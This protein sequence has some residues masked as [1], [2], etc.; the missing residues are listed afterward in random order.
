MGNRSTG[1][2]ASMALVVG[3]PSSVSYSALIINRHQEM[4]FGNPGASFDYPL[5]YTVGEANSYAQFE[6]TS[7]QSSSMVAI[8]G[9]S[10]ADGILYLGG[11]NEYGGGILYHGSDLGSKLPSTFADTST[12]LYRS[13][14]SV[15]EPVLDFPSDNNHI[16]VRLDR[17]ADSDNLDYFGMGPTGG[18]NVKPWKKTFMLNKQTTS[19]SINIKLGEVP[20][21]GVG[22]YSIKY[23]VGKCK[24]NSPMNASAVIEKMQNWR[25]ELPGNTPIIMIGGSASSATTIEAT[26][27]AIATGTT[28][29]AGAGKLEF[30]STGDASFQV[31]HNGF[32]EVTFFPYS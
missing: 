14:K 5:G 26:D 23:I 27:G 21:S 28:I 19:D 4:T 17:E 12:A 1:S 25:V 8:K 16:M 3:G 15:A 30:F 11:S 32:V 9:A 24:N 6:N 20:A 13:S 31:V 2:D 18:A 10:G 29:T 7:N 22:V